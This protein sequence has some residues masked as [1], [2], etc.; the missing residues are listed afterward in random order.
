MAEATVS[1]K[2][3]VEIGADISGLSQSLAR[4]GRDVNAFAGGTVSAAARDMSR[5]FEGSARSLE[6]NLVRAARS[7]RFSIS[8][9]VDAILADLAR[10][11][12]RRFVTAPLERAVSSV[13]GSIGSGLAGR[14]LGGPTAAAN[15][16]LVGERGPEV[17]VPSGNGEIVPAGRISTSRPQIVVNV[18]TQDARSFVNSEGQ[19]AAM[20]TRAVS[21]GVRNL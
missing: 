8:A 14:A 20:L 16:Y 9:M 3:V 7:G 18:Q 6:A 5:A 12:I 10:I 21:R 17:F 1:D 11:A 2:L 15:P 13:A 19:I 4:A